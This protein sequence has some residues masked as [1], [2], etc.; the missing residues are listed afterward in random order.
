MESARGDSKPCTRGACPGT[1]QFGREPQRHASSAT[2]D[3][4]R[5]WICSVNPAHFQ[6]ASERPRRETAPTGPQARW[7]DDGGSPSGEPRSNRP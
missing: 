2:A 4:P 1:M 7:D 6:L 5:G 3:A